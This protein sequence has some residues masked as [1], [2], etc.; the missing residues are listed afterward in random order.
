[1]RLDCVGILPLVWLAFVATANGTLPRVEVYPLSARDHMILTDESVNYSTY[2]KLCGSGRSESTRIAGHYERLNLTDRIWTFDANTNE[3]GFFQAGAVQILDPADVFSFN[4]VARAMCI[5]RTARDSFEGFSVA[6]WEVFV[7]AAT[8]FIAIFTSGWYWATINTSVDF[9]PHMLAAS[10]HQTALKWICGMLCLR[11]LSFAVGFICVENS[12]MQAAA[13]F[14][15]IYYAFQIM[16]TAIL[17][18]HL[19]ATVHLRSHFALQSR[20]YVIP[21]AALGTIFPYLLSC[22]PVANWFLRTGLHLVGFVLGSVSYPESNRS[23]DQDGVLLGYLRSDC[24]CDVFD[25]LHAISTGPSP[26]AG[27]SFEGQADNFC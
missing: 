12:Y 4:L 15:G 8:A 20:L 1:M 11:S 22:I 26:K 2:T 24:G 23:F 13:I 18:L 21:V 9:G 5:L 6:P 17:I 7:V 3:I 14:G 10:N 25:Y 27:R 16:L 19:L